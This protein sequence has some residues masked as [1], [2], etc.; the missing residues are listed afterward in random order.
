MMKYCQGNVIHWLF[1]EYCFL[2]FNQIRLST[3]WE[4]NSTS[5]LSILVRGWSELQIMKVP[6][7]A[8][9]FSSTFRWCKTSPMENQA[10][11]LILWHLTWIF[12]VITLKAF[13]SDHW[14]VLRGHSNDTWH[15]SDSLS[16]KMNFFG[17]FL[18]P[19]NCVFFSFF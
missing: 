5:L 3:A 18:T 17:P 7:I 8:N 13:A 1:L 16:N 11:I 12:N 15:F 10:C 6:C 19:T 9:L 4:A 14:F 2:I